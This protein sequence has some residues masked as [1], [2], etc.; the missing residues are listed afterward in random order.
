M[1]VSVLRRLGFEW[2]CPSPFQ[3]RCRKAASTTAAVADRAAAAEPA[4]PAAGAGS[5]SPAPSVGARHGSFSQIADEFAWI[6]I[7]IQLFKL[8]P[9]QQGRDG[10]ARN[11]GPSTHSVSFLLDFKLISGDVLV[12]LH[13][14]SE[15]ISA[16]TPLLCSSS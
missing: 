16:L 7:G 3:L 5:T 14:L 8:N 13:N 11:S 15:I 2:K 9:H 6:K 1:S 10:S 12:V 4:T